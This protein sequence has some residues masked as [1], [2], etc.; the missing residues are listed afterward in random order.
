MCVGTERGSSKSS[1]FAFPQLCLE[2]SLFDEV[3]EL[4]TVQVTV[5]WS[6]LLVS[7][8]IP[9]GPWHVYRIV[10]VHAG[11]C[12]VSPYVIVRTVVVELLT[13]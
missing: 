11:W 9:H 4:A 6:S 3:R 1:L 12:V 8:H 2:S 5:D 7:T 13:Y 10:R